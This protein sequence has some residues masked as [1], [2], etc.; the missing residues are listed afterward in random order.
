MKQP[1]FLG[2]LRLKRT[3]EIATLIQTLLPEEDS[4]ALATDHRLVWSV[5]ARDPDAHRCFLW[6][7]EDTQGRYLTLSTE[8]PRP[9]SA[10]FDVEHKPFQPSMAPGDRIGF[11][12]R[13]NATVDRRPDGRSGRTVRSDVAMDLLRQIP[14]GGDERA[15]ARQHLAEKAAR[16]WLEA[17]A[18]RDGFHVDALRL[19]AYRPMRL[20]RPGGKNATIGVFDLQ[21]AL[22][23]ANPEAF[24]ARIAEGFGRAKAFGCGLMLIRRLPNA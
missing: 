7:R 2:R 21:G 19:D 3:P 15:A 10:L 24:L 20:P 6:R 18:E 4:Q 1:L 23:V 8:P 12:L 16:E 13:V 5:F 14:A 11:A 9:D 17:R 22:R